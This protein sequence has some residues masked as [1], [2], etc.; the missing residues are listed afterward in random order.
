[1]LL[2]QSIYIEIHVSHIVAGM[3]IEI[4]NDHNKVKIRNFSYLIFTF[5]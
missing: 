5:S 3:N 1:M 4:I 2:K